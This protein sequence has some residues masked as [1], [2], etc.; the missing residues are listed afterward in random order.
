MPQCFTM[1]K[2]EGQNKLIQLCN[3][4]VKDSTFFFFPTRKLRFE[5][6]R[7]LNDYEKDVNLPLPENV[8]IKNTI[9]DSNGIR[10]AKSS[11]LWP[12]ICAS[13]IK[14]EI[15]QEKMKT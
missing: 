13:G 4:E 9:I 12:E 1:T 7:L 2:E 6:T 3:D 5:T 11:Y 15:V 8:S 14:T 10:T